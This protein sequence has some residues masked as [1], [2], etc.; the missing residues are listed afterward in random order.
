VDSYY[1][2]WRHEDAVRTAAWKLHRF[3]DHVELYD[4]RTDPNETTDVSAAN[5]E[6]VKE[7]IRKMEA[8]NGSLQAAP[9]H[10]PAPARLHGEPKPEGEVLAVEVTVTDKAKPRDML[11]VPFAGGEG[12]CQATDWIEFDV[13]FA[14]TASKGRPFYSP[15]KGAEDAAKLLFTNGVGVDQLGRG[16]SSGPVSDAGKIVWEHRI[17]GL[18]AGAPGPLSRHGIVFWGLPPGGYVVYIDNLR[19]RHADGSTTPIWSGSSDTA[20][21][22]IADTPAFRSVRVRT[23]SADSL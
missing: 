8:W 23:V 22:R 2:C 16:Q 13:A 10:L 11:V 4:M 1:W 18:A 12:R 6:V 3:A 19:V 21:R 17:I 7:L 15:F 5:P 20:A 9:S 14:P